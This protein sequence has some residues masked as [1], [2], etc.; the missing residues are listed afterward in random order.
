MKKIYTLALLLCFG[1]WLFARAQ[2]T[3]VCNPGFNVSTSQHTATFQA[4]D[5]HLA[6]IHS[7]VFGDGYSLTSYSSSASHT[8]SAA[9]Y[10]TVKHIIRDSVSGV[11]HD[12]TMRLVYIDSVPQCQIYIALHGDSGSLPNHYR[13]WAGPRSPGDS[14]S[15][16]INDS[17]VVRND[18][19][20]AHDF[21]IGYYTVCVRLHALSGCTASSCY[22]FTVHAA[23]SSSD[24]T[25]TPPPPPPHDSCSISFTYSSSA[26]HPNEIHFVAHDSTGLDSLAWFITRGVDTVVL[27]GPAPVYVF[28]DTGCYNVVLYAMT[29]GGCYSYSGQSVCIDSLP[30]SNYIA[31]YPNPARGESRLDVK[32]DRDNMIYINIYNSMGHLVLSKRVDGIG[33]M[34]QIVLPTADLPKGVYYVQIRYGN[35]SKRSKIQKL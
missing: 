29:P 10:Y 20:F 30:G 35:V 5:M 16:Y 11:C 32:L 17:L 26:A 8:Y 19:G 23:D 27:H 22:S 31:S 15:W 21:G 4:W 24:T 33:G 28:A 34:N 3:T 13:F 6:V 7:W 25:H 2:D 12:S 1:S 9:G 18:T 14:L